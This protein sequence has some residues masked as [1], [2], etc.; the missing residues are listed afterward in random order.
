MLK[1]IFLATGL[2][3]A[4]ATAAY[5]AEPANILQT[6]KGATLVNASGLILYVFDKDP[7][8]KSVCNGACATNWPPFEAS[9]MAASEGDYSVVSRDDGAHQWA[10]KGKSLYRWVKDV[11]PGDISGDGLLGGTWHVAQP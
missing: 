11:K 1:Q 3:F 7:V 10:Y 4:A 8:G 5:A 9:G 6:A 2:A